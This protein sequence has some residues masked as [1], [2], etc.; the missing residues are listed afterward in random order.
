MV[1]GFMFLLGLQV[2]VSNEL[3]RT[4]GMVFHYASIPFTISS[5]RAVETRGLLIPWSEISHVKCI[6]CIY[7]YIY[8]HPP[9]PTRIRGMVGVR[10]PPPAPSLTL[11]PDPPP[12]FR[13]GGL[14]PPPQP[15]DLKF[16]KGFAPQTTLW[17]SK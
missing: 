11:P 10:C 16:M 2:H 6:I 15:P 5:V 13:A 9:I 8:K 17:G 3:R 14:C 7:I 12:E 1:M 4:V